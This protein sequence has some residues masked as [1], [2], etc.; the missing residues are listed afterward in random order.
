MSALALRLPPLGNGHDQ[1]VPLARR[2]VLGSG[3][4][5]G[6]AHIRVRRFGQLNGPQVLALGG[7]SAGRDVCGETGWWRETLID[8]DAI[9]LS[10]F[11]VLGID[12]A[13]LEDE[14]VRLSPRDQ[15]RLIVTALNG[16]GVDRLHGF[17]GASYGGMVGLAFAALA[18]E[19]VRRLCVISAAHKPS[20]QSLAWRGIQRRIVEY[21]QAHGDAGSGLALARQLAMVTYRTAGEFEQRFGAGVDTNGRGEVDKYLV[22]RGE[23]Y[24]EAVAPQ[25]W[26]SLSESIDRA[27]VDPAEVRATVTLA[28]CVDDQLVP[29]ELVEDLA[30]RLPNLRALHRLSSP[31]GHDAFLKEPARIA[32]IINACLED[33]VDD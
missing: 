30:R 32:A 23:A 8:H 28:A 11:G 10:R 13:P 21:A 14:R 2:F 6:D 12:F 29:V 9:D 33:R 31:Y 4:V 7:I 17:V 27:F 19:R 3:D 26:L 20:A 25:R 24:A 15:A 22:A 16:L 1:T 5:L 18:P